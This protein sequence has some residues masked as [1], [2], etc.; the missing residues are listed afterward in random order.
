M[1]EPGAAWVLELGRLLN[2]HIRWEERELFP[3]IERSASAEQL[4][5]LTQETE[6]LEQGRARKV[7]RSR[8]S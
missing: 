6:R 8:P 7:R 4:R 5:N 1:S 2:D 3:L